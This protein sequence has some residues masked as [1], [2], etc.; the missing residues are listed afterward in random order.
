M[1]SRCALE[2]DD[3]NTKFAQLPQNG[4]MDAAEQRATG[5]W[6]LTNSSERDI[7]K[8]GSGIVGTGSGRLSAPTA[9]TLGNNSPVRL[10]SIF[11]NSNDQLYYNAKKIKPL[12]GYSDIVVHGSPTALLA[13]DN[14]GMELSYNAKEAAELIKNSREFCGKPIRLISCNAGQGE[15]CIAQQISDILGVDVLAPTEAVYVNGFGEMLVTDNAGLSILWEMGIN[16]K[17]TGTWV[18]FSPRKE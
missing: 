4:G 16:V 6:V 1:N 15:N 11:V 2:F 9:E 8:T 17:D 3:E 10:S 12:K 14:D 7:M 13:Y 18:L 5:G